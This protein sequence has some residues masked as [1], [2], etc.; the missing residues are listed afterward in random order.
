MLQNMVT[1]ALKFKF[2]HRITF[3]FF[4][5]EKVEIDFARKKQHNQCSSVYICG[6]VKARG[7]LKIFD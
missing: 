3:S 4:K 1:I 6:A 7:Y 2:L 5:G